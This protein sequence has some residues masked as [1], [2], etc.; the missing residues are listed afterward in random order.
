M[1][2]SLGFPSSPLVTPE[3]GMVTP[4]WRR[5]FMRLLPLPAAL[6]AARALAELAQAAATTAQTTIDTLALHR[7]AFIAA[8]VLPGAAVAI[9]PVT[10]VDLVSQGLTEGDYDVWFDVTF[11]GGLNARVDYFQVSISPTSATIDA[12]RANTMTSLG[13]PTIR[14]FNNVSQYSVSVGPLRVTVAPAATPT[15]FGVIRSDFSIVGTLQAYGILR[16]RR[17]R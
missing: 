1:S 8:E 5:Y 7:G 16:A 4:A 13:F 12:S 11:T 14:L 2:D 17:V 10:P 15:Y 9:V 3:M 6:T